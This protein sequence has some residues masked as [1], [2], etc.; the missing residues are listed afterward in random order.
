MNE[1]T[2]QAIHAITGSPACSLNYFWKAVAILHPIRQRFG[3]CVERLRNPRDSIIAR[4]VFNTIVRRDTH[5]V[6]DR[7]DWLWTLH[8]FRSEMHGNIHCLFASFH[9]FLHRFLHRF[10][11]SFIHC[12]FERIVFRLLLSILEAENEAFSWSC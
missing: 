2:K 10:L 7:R 11:H 4:A 3:N 6:L 1:T 9:G 8:T 5:H 12:F